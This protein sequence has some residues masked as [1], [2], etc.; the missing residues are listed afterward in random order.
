[1]AVKFVNKF[2]VGWQA[3][4]EADD[5]YLLGGR[6]IVHGPIWDTF[7]AALSHMNG[8]IARNV[9]ANRSV[10]L[11]KVVPFRG[12]VSCAVHVPDE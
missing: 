12:L 3:I 5:G 8:V 7:F 11:G 10:K 4:V 6:T 2:T 9:Q 1:M